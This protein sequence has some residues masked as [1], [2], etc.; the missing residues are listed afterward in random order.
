MP[1]GDAIGNAPSHGAAIGL[2]G[3]RLTS[4]IQEN[5][6][7]AGKA[8]SYEDYML[9][10]SGE[11]KTIV[12]DSSDYKGDNIVFLPIVYSATRGPILIDYYTDVTADDNGI[13]L[14]SSNRR[15]G[16]PN[17]KSILRLNPTNF[18]GVRF[19]GDLVPATGLSNA[20]SNGMSN[21]SN[22]LG[23]PFEIL[24]DR[25]HAITIENKNGDGVYVLIKMTW[26]E[27]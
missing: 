2:Q 6:F 21:E 15:E 7:V 3:S 24:A 17:A 8:F 26:F 9:Y 23:I 14:A 12:L 20:T 13:L 18:S 25:K 10:S 16:F 11:I 4:S 27:V 19:T 22:V 1:N 5:L